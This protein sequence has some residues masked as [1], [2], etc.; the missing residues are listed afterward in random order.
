MIVNYSFENFQSYKD[1]CDVDFSVT[2]KTPDSYY[3]YVSSSNKK[4]AKVMAV[5]GANGSGKSNLLKPLS[6]VAW[7]ASTSFGDM[8]KGE[9]IP[10][11]PHS[12][13][14]NDSS[15]IKIDFILPRWNNDDQADTDIEFRY[16][17]EVKDDHVLEETL[18]F[19]T[20]RQYSRVFERVYDKHSDSY[21]VKLNS[22]LGPDIP[23]S[24][25]ANAPRNCSLI[26]YIDNLKESKDSPVCE[27]SN[28]AVVSLVNHY[29]YRTFS[30]LTFQGRAHLVNN[31]DSAIKFYSDYPEQFEFAKKLLK[32]YDMG[33][34]DIVL[35]E[36]MLVNNRDGSKTKELLPFCI[37]KTEESEFQI[38]LFMESS[39]TQSAFCTLAMVCE[40][41]EAGSLIV[42]DEFDNDFHPELTMAIVNLY[43]DEYTNPKNAQLLFNTHTVEVL[44][45]IKRQHCY[46]VEKHHGNSEAYRGD[47]IEGLKDRDNLY[48]KYVSGALGAYPEID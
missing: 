6:F 14:E 34:D 13:R 8:K 44:K 21:N 4:V 7:F 33:I 43:K 10:V 41:L 42:L 46:F 29:F 23:K 40:S 19:K 39:G 36:T 38:P 32:S 30:N 1:V 17:L 28:I 25:L 47:D 12:L 26:S 22:V 20:S 18:K 3:D 16:L 31:I 9:K 37:H 2:N 35:E 11:I 5:I 24:I 27:E 45:H 48:K 15:K